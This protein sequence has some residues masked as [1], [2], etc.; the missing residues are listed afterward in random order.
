MFYPFF[1]YH[2]ISITDGAVGKKERAAHI[3]AKTNRI[4]TGCG[5][6][7]DGI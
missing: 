6:G 2:G 4:R 7:N 3:D 5:I 1:I